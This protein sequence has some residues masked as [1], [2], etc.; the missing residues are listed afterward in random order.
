[1]KKISVMTPMD[2]LERTQ[3]IIDY[4]ASSIATKEASALIEQAG[5]FIILSDASDRIRD[6]MDEISVMARGINIV[7]AE[8]LEQNLIDERFESIM[9]KYM[10][11]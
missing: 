8:A 4:M 11:A 3:C 10:S 6:A 2:I 7:L 9:D 5:A 1:M